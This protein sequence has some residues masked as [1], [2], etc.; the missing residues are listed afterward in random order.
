MMNSGQ[1][2]PSSTFENASA[3]ILNNQDNPNFQNL[4]EKA[5]GFSSLMM[6]S[7]TNCAHLVEHLIRRNYVTR[8][9][10]GRIAVTQETSASSCKGYNALNF[11]CLAGSEK[12]IKRLLLKERGRAQVENKVNSITALQYLQL[13]KAQLEAQ[14]GK[15]Y[16]PGDHAAVQKA[17]VEMMVGLVQGTK[18][19]VIQVMSYINTKTYAACIAPL[20]AFVDKQKKRD[21]VR[22]D[23]LKEFATTLAGEQGLD[24]DTA[25]ITLKRSLD[26][27][28]PMHQVQADRHHERLAEMAKRS[29]DNSRPGRNLKIVQSQLAGAKLLGAVALSV[30]VSIGEISKQI[31]GIKYITLFFESMYNQYKKYQKLNKYVSSVNDL[32]CPLLECIERAKAVSVLSQIVRLNE[33]I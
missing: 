32:L 6:A 22:N 10:T 23:F 18:W 20:E 3:A 29:V 5:T 7:F 13:R 24:Q 16:N 11:A 33:L 15:G 12:A 9:S 21:A 30:V 1:I 26:K 19:S 4:T 2:G 25:L 17:T 14:K 27:N 28:I 31:P 8:G